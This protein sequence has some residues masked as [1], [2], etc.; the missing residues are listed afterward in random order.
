[1]LSQIPK[2]LPKILVG[3]KADALPLTF[4]A[5]KAV[6]Q[7]DNIVPQV[8]ISALTGQGESDFVEIILQACGR[9]ES[10]GLLFALNERQ[11]DLA[12]LSID[13]LK[14]SS[15]VA[16]QQLPW[17]FWT[18]DL[19]QAIHYLGEITGDEITEAVLDRI[20]SKFCIGK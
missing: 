12:K 11:C 20:F 15:E 6:Y 10:Q 7:G 1:M 19:R 18:I 8:M 5:N 3:N 2:D 13:A 9:L 4:Q 14:R 16:Y 17:D